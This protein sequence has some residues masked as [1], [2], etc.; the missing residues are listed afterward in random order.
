MLLVTGIAFCEVKGFSPGDQT[1]T[2]EST[3]DGSE[4]LYRIYLPK[5]V[6]SA[7]PVPLLVVLHGKTV[8]HNAWFDYTPIK[9]F[10]DKYGYVVVAPYGRGDYFYQGPAERD[11]LDIMDIVLERDNID[12]DRVYLM[13]HSMGGWG[14]WWIGLR[15]PER[16][17][18]IC[19]MAGFCP[20]ELLPN[21]FHLAPYIVHDASDPIVSVEHSRAAA[22]RLERLGQPYVYREEHGYGHSSKMIGDNLDRLFLWMNAHRRNLRPGHVRFVTRTPVSGDA[23]WMR[24]LETAE[25]PKPAAL[26]AQLDESAQLLLAAKGVKKFAFDLKQFM[27]K[28]HFPIRTQLDGQ[29]FTLLGN[30]GWGI[31]TRSGTAGKWQYH[32][33][34]EVPPPYVSPVVGQVQPKEGAAALGQA[35]L[36]DA[37]VKLLLEQVEADVALFTEDMFIGKLA[38]GPLSAD[39]VLDLY[40]YSEKRLG[41]F[42]CTGERFKTILETESPPGKEWWG[43]LKPVGKEV[44]DPEKTYKVIAPLHV[45]TTFE[46]EPE[47]LSETIPEYLY[48]AIHK[49]APITLGP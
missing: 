22:R 45:A 44:A 31:F 12:P 27:G 39:Q 32:H 43:R 36:L 49:K 23:Y 41:R 20:L 10:A 18:A 40:V 48:Q 7:T 24:V 47:V 46:K 13:G 30:F 5:V 1:I 21:A 2:F 28:S 35:E 38:A 29:T 33:Q 9:E 37:A 26:E 11:V 8:D 4:Q 25:F 6:S 34:R 3:W 19:P 14:T 16:F 15:H 42:E 17:A